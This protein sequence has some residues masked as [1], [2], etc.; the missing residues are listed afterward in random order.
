MNII[1][2]TIG[3]KVWF[4]PNGSH[5][6]VPCQAQ[7]QCQDP[8]QAMDATIVLV[9]A[10]HC[11]NLLVI[12]HAGISWPVCSVFLQQEGDETP[13]GMYA[14]WTPYQAG[15]AKK[16][17]QSA[18][19]ADIGQAAKSGMDT[20]VRASE[21]V[22]VIPARLTPAD[23]EASIAS[24]HYFTAADGVHGTHEVPGNSVGWSIPTPL[25]M[26]T[27][28]VLVLRN[29]FKVVGLNHGDIDPA[30]H[31]QERGK[32]EARAMALEKVWELEGYLLRE[33]LRHP[34]GALANV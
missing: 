31:D 15:R 17:A 18:G 16:D 28:C 26:L 5:I 33:H 25:K 13:K 10:E 34:V 8:A 20:L 27:F 12:D 9:H 22:Q 3:Q 11:V 4:W 30:V 7:P 1:K 19:Y 23:I 29:G 2:P 14:Q 21:P 24:E 32:R 6:G